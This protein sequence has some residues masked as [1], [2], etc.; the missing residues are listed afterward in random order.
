HDATAELRT[1]SGAC[2]PPTTDELRL[3]SETVSK[4]STVTE[5]NTVATKIRKRVAGSAKPVPSRSEGFQNGSRPLASHAL[6]VES[7]SDSD[8]NVQPMPP[9]SEVSSPPEGAAPPVIGEGATPHA[10]AP[11]DQTPQTGTA[12]HSLP[13]K[14]TPELLAWWQRIAQTQRHGLFLAV[15]CVLAPCILAIIGGIIALA[16]GFRLWG[17]SFLAQAVLSI[18]TIYILV[19]LPDWTTTRNCGLFFGLMTFLCALGTGLLAFASPQHLRSWHLEAIH[20]QSLRWMASLTLVYFTVTFVLLRVSDS[21]R[22]K[23]D[24]F[25]RAI[26]KGHHLSKRTAQSAP[27]TTLRRNPEPAPST[28]QSNP[29]QLT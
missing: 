29:Q 5:P 12:S 15:G 10:P 9:W 24:A 6:G 20:N 4:D 2:Y 25:V 1:P 3:P 21:Q 13:P 7:P 14:V 16:T 18:G 22:R 8:A 23:A 11:E 17:W 26:R 28:S 19:A 27:P